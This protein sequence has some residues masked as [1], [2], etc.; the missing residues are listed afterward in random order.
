MDDLKRTVALLF[1]RKGRDR[2]TEKEFVLGAS[3]DLRWFPPA[4]AQRLL[5]LGLQ[6]GL[7]RMEGG[8]VEPAFDPDEV[9][10]PLDFVPGR[11]MLEEEPDLFEELVETLVQGTGAPR[12]EVVARVNELRSRLGVYPEVAAL[13]AGDHL[14]VDLSGYR[15]AV[16]ERVGRRPPTPRD[17]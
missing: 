8:R 13:L 11:E 2:L 12:K 7:L 6:R 1:R 14:G 4:D 5:D 3:M 17:G 16:E 10:V 15:E 9:E